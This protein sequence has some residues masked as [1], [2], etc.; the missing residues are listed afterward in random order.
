[1]QK[2]SYNSVDAQVINLAL[3]ED[4]LTSSVQIPDDGDTGEWV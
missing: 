4:I 3:E 1:M 2:R